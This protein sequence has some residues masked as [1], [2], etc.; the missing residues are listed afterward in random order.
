[1]QPQPNSPEPEQSKPSGS[2]WERKSAPEGA[3]SRRWPWLVALLA[4]AA[5]AGY[6]YWTRSQDQERQT[7]IASVGIRTYKVEGGGRLEN[8]LLLTGQTESTPV[9]GPAGVERDEITDV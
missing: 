6:F 4:V 5:G 9:A 8:T 7:R 3:Q 2:S 1:M